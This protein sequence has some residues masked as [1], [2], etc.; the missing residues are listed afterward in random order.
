M[1]VSWLKKC[2]VCDY[3]AEKVNPCFK[4]FPCIAKR[5]LGRIRW[6]F[7]CRHLQKVKN[8]SEINDVIVDRKEKDYFL[9]VLSH[10]FVCHSFTIKVNKFI[11]H[12]RKET[13]S[14]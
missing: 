3:T 9:L 8:P 4:R 13:L 1:L 12:F 10:D 2:A 6:K 5:Y 14:R 7:F 11:I